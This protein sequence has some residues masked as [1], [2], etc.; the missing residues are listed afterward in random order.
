M[1]S[2][3]VKEMMIP[4]EEY[5]TVSEEADLY[6]AVR[7][8]EEAREK[9]SQNNYRHRAVLVYGADRRIVGKLSQLDLIR[10]L[11]PKYKGLDELK[12]LSRF[13]V[14]P[15]QVHQMIKDYGL[16]K[17]PL[18]D[19]CKS[20]ARFKVKDVMATPTEK[21]HIAEDASLQEA[22]H[23][24]VMGCHQSLLVTRASDIVGILRLTDVFSKISDL[25][26]ACRL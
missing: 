15:E 17:S 23:Q 22:V 24:L 16:W 12:E 1:K 9:Y 2:I 25:I 21:E 26:K 14:H 6:E 10:G 11:E 20:A 3:V 13:G 8:L 18:E 19:I 4:L 5:A 7:A